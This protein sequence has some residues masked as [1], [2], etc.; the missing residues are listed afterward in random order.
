VSDIAQ[1]F[2]CGIEKLVHDSLSD[3]QA[4]LVDPFLVEQ[5]NRH[6]N[7]TNHVHHQCESK[8][9]ISCLVSEGVED[10][11]EAT[12]VPKAVQHLYEAL[13]EAA[14]KAR[15]TVDSVVTRRRLNDI[16]HDLV[17]ILIFL[18]YAVHTRHVLLNT[19][20]ENWN[21]LVI[22]AGPA[23]EHTA[24]IFTNLFADRA[25]DTE[26]T[27]A[28]KDLAALMLLECDVKDRTFLPLVEVVHVN[29]TVHRRPL[30]GPGLAP[31]IVLLGFCL[32]FRDVDRPAVEVVVKIGRQVGNLH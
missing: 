21:V 29:L 31:L 22:F 17:I 14:A 7:H 10:S 8:I 4:E 20:A 28:D 19:R 12:T 9:L 32:E 13:G 24:L 23:I 2:V 3:R 18:L 26:T 6:G 15:N 16:V 25:I 1:N 30:F 11:C 5:F 27:V